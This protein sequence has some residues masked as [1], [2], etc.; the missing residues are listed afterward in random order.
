MTEKVNCDICGCA[1]TEVLYTIQSYNIARCARCGLVFTNPR[2]SE[3]EI[4][5]IYSSQEYYQSATPTIIG[6]EN[7]IADKEDIT[8]T[9]SRKLK[10]IEGMR[11]AKGRILD[12]GCAGGFFLEAAKENG[13]DPYGIEISKYMAEYAQ[14]SFGERVFN[15]ALAAKKYPDGYFD[16]ITMWDVI[17]HMP[18][19]GSELLETNRIIKKD[20]LLVVQTPNIGSYIAM[21]MRKNWLCLQ[22]P[23]EHIYYFSPETIRLILKK[24]GFE[25]IRTTSTGSG[26]VCTLEFVIG[27]LRNYNNFIFSRLAKI[28]KILGIEKAAFYVNIGD[29]MIT[30]ARK[31]G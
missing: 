22:R 10:V 30:Y 19:P 12:I 24:A 20:G 6:Y 18:R 3:D 11:E 21:L 15:G 4:N 7:Y 27:R 8:N 31:K 16:V 26:K 5:K 17:E 9:F 2:L 1:Q 29:N 28:I 14:K 13:W 25:V 23:V